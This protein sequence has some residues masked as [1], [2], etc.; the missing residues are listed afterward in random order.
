MDAFSKER[1]ALSREAEYI[2]I[3][4]KLS[5]SVEVLTNHIR[6]YVVTLDPSELQKYWYEIDVRKTRERALERLK[7]LQASKEEIEY[8]NEAKRN[9][10]DLVETEIRGMKLIL[11]VF[12]VQ[13]DKMHPAIREYSLKTEDLI[14]DDNAKVN[15]AREIMFDKKYDENRKK[16]LI[17]ILKFQKAMKTRMTEETI[18]A[19]RKTD[20]LYTNVVIFST[21]ILLFVIGIIWLRHSTYEEKKRSGP[22][23]GKKGSN[24]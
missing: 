5:D 21:L 6:K 14:L 2:Q 9:S 4:N 15:K 20:L 16:I 7:I 8:L 24:L 22:D 12:G 10:D 1:F 19:N 11:K 17:P 13:E 18:K 3:G 23:P